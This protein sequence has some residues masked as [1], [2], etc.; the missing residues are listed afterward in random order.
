MTFDHERALWSWDIGGIHATRD[1]DNV[2]ELLAAKLTRLPV[3]TQNALL[4]FACL[5]NIADVALLSI[6]LGGSEDQVH[7]VLWE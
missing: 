6:V 5:G 4:Q 7:A 2:V 3:D 1:M